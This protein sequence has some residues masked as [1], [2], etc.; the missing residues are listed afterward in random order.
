MPWNVCSPIDCHN[1]IRSIAS[2]CIKPAGS[3]W[4]YE[5]L[6]HLE[7]TQDEL[8]LTRRSVYSSAIDIAQLAWN[9]YLADKTINPTAAE[10][11]YLRNEISWKKRARVRKKTA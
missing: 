1:A 3:G 7:L 5:P 10:P 4:D 6:K 9:E 11:T 8:P 2:S